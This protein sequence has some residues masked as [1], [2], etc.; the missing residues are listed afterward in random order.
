MPRF[1]AR[2]TLQRAL[3]ARG[4]LEFGTFPPRRL[5]PL[6]EPLERDE[7]TTWALEMW[8]D[9]RHAFRRWCMGDGSTLFEFADD[10]AV[11][12][13]LLRFG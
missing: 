11:M 1:D 2:Q 12:E 8:S 7:A 4:A 10:I 5:L 6:S 9:Q 3:K 13:F